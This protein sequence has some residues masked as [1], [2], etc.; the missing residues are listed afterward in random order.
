[1]SVHEHVEPS[2]GTDGVRARA[3]TELTPEFALRLGRALARVLPERRMVIAHDPRSSGPIIEAALCAGLASEGVDV[4][5]LGI[6]PTPA[7]AFMSAREGVPGIVV[8]ASHNLHEDNGVKVFAAGGRKLSDA[9]QSAVEDELEKLRSDSNVRQMPDRVGL[10]TRRLDAGA[11]Y[12]DHLVGLFGEGA[13]AGMRVVI[14]TA[15]GA[16]SVVAPDVLSRLGADIVVLNDAPTGTNINDGCGATSPQA[17]CEFV[18]EAHGDLRV[19]I[20][21]AFDGD[22]DR[23]IA[24]DENGTI[25]DGDRL[26]ALSALE[27]LGTGTLIGGTVVVTVMTNLGFHR[28]MDAAG[29]QVVTTPV[30]DRSVLHE[31]E[32]HGYV[33]GGEQSGHIIHRDLATTGDGLL[34]GIVLARLCR[35]E[36]STNARMFSDLAESVM[37][38]VPQVLRAVAVGTKPTDVDDEIGTEL[39]AA[40]TRLGQRGRVLVRKSGTEPV[41]RVMVEADDARIAADIADELV[42][43]VVSRWGGREP[44][45]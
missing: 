15:N 33:I 41:V 13:L 40:R 18:A 35:R 8:T 23:V 14:D 21:F 42:A 3:L 29:V 43:A 17:L 36:K 44:G 16:M 25:V 34:A 22:G 26:I 5:K 11:E 37:T 24:V 2:F 38:T 4:E 30:G 31:M 45:T 20:G 27:R 12:A 6:L 9:L 7:V 19:D 10:I 32:T 39:A 28:A 1:V